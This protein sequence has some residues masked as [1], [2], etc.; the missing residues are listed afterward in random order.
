MRVGR[1]YL[2]EELLLEL[3]LIGWT[4]EIE[5]HTW[6]QLGRVPDV[7]T[8]AAPPNSAQK[9]LVDSLKALRDKASD[10]PP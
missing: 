9:D 4:V 6:E 1:L 5:Y 3:P 7:F 8:L 2:P 10:P